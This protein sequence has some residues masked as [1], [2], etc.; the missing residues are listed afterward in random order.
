M[1]PA[2]HLP[3]MLMGHLTQGDARSKMEQVHRGN[4]EGS[5]QLKWGEPWVEPCAALPLSS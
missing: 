5:R 2:A 3:Q 4:G 1:M